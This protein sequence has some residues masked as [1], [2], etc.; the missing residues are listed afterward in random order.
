MERPSLLHPGLNG[1][2]GRP[3]RVRGKVNGHPVVITAGSALPSSR[4]RSR[5]EPNAMDAP[6][7]TPRFLQLW[8]TLISRAVLEG[9]EHHLDGLIALIER[10]DAESEQMT[11]RYQAIDILALD[12]PH[13]QVVA[14]LEVPVER[15]A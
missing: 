4:T 7:W 6:T 3:V 9:H 2:S 13:Q 12:D 10:M 8:P 1:G 15:R 5:A 11:S 14:V